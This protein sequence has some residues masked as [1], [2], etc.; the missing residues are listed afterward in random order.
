MAKV[1]SR[2]PMPAVLVAKTVATVLTALVTVPLMAPV[3]VLTLRGLGK[4]VAPY[5]VGSWV[6]VMA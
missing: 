3:E 6:P 4:P 2:L 5:P 1:T